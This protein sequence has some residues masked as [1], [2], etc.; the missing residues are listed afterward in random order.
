VLSNPGFVIQH[1]LTPAKLSYLAL[2]ALPTLG[3]FVFGARAL[4]ALSFGLIFTALATGSNLQH[5]YLHYTVFTFPAMAAVA[6]LG[7]RNLV[8]RLEP[9]RRPV[10][11]ASVALVLV[12]ASV[13]AGERFGALG[14]SEAFT[15]G[16]AQLIHKLDAHARERHAWLTEAVAKIPADASVAATITLGPHVSSR[17]RFYHFADRPDADWLVLL[18]QHVSRRER[19]RLRKQV[20]EGELERVAAYGDEITIYRRR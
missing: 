9:A 11:L 14:R 20:R 8:G 13:L 3:L 1:A 18:E 7:L 16:H 10:F 2:L 17:A 4:W 5:P 6:V 19:L 15:A 12:C